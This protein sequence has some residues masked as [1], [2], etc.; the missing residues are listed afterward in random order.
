MWASLWAGGFLYGALRFLIVFH[1]HFCYCGILQSTEVCCWV[2]Q[3]QRRDGEADDFFRLL[4]VHREAT[5]LCTWLISILINKE[6]HLSTGRLFLPVQVMSTSTGFI[7]AVHGHSFAFLP[8]YYGLS[9]GY[10][11]SHAGS[12]GKVEDSVG[13]LK[14]L[15]W[16]MRTRFI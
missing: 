13:P 9:L 1:S 6:N 8:C 16:A 5:L 2:C 3:L 7:L 12:C 10:F 4:K 11:L 14:C 15:R